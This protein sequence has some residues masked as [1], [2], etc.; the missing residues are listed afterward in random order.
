[1]LDLN[2]KKRAA[3]RI[4]LA[5]TAAAVVALPAFIGGFATHGV[6]VVPPARADSA[7]TTS[8]P[9]VQMV[10]ASFADLAAKVTPAVVNISSTHVETADDQ[11]DMPFNVPKGS[12]FEQFFQ[13]FMQQQGKHNPMK[14]KATALGSGF[15]IDPS[16]YI[17]TNNHV[18]ESATDIQVTTTDGTLCHQPVGQKA[19]VIEPAGWLAGRSIIGIT[20]GASTPNNK[21]GETIARVCEVAGVL[22]ALER[23][24]ETR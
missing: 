4:G 9:M 3:R 20:A 11:Q 13:Q 18:I 10:P 22:P 1:M 2:N 15:V 23:A 5:A 8:A 17:V 12:P 21:V 14:R 16:G 6:T 24:L 7:T 19:E